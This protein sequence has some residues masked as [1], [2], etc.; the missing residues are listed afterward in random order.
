MSAEQ[1]ARL[2]ELA[3]QEKRSLNKTILFAIDKYIEQRK[4]A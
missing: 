2:C 4:N 1:K 3:E